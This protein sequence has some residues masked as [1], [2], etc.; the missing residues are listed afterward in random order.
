MRI[1]I[2]FIVL[3]LGFF[4]IAYF[5]PSDGFSSWRTVAFVIFACIWSIIFIKYRRD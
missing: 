3:F 5:I 4:V 2:S 1:V